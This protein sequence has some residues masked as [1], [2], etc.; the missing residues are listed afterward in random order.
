MRRRLDAVPVLA[1]RY[2]QFC[3]NHDQRQSADQ[4]EVREFHHCRD[5]GGEDDTQH[6]SRS[7]AEN[8]APKPLARLQF[9]TRQR[10]HQRVVTGQQHVDPDDFGESYPELRVMDFNVELREYSAYC[11]RIEKFRE[12]GQSD[13]HER[14]RHHSLSQNSEGVWRLFV[15]NPEGNHMV[16]GRERPDGVRPQTAAGVCISCNL[17]RR[18]IDPTT[19]TMAAPNDANTSSSISPSNRRCFTNPNIDEVV[20][21]FRLTSP[22]SN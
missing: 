21:I 2:Q 5:N 11:G 12:P 19:S 14:L 9:T 15:A 8:H 6:H 17:R 3:S 10:N 4:L 22:S 18:Q 13:L 16:S 1:L 7:R 20:S